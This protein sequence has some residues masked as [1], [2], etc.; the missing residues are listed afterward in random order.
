MFVTTRAAGPLS[1]TAPASAAFGMAGADGVLDGAEAAGAE[2][3]G[4]VVA[5]EAGIAGV[6]T[7]ALAMVATGRAPT[8]EGGV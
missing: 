4:A 2:A 1:T 8:A 5:G 3:A 7:G 6:A